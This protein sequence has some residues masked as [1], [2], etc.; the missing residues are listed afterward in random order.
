MANKFQFF[1]CEFCCLQNS[2]IYHQLSIHWNWLWC[3]TAT[4]QKHYMKKT[5]SSLECTDLQNIFEMP[6]LKK[7]K[8]ENFIIYNRKK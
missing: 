2:Q 1:F 8:R 3:S 5:D 4:K 6:K 7:K